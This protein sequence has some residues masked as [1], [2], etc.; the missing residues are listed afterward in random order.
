MASKRNVRDDLNRIA[1]I[2]IE[3]ALDDGTQQ[4]QQKPK[5]RRMGVVKTLVAGAALVGAARI[6]V[7]RAPSLPRVPNLP[8]ISD[9]SDLG[10]RVR[11]RLDEVL[12]QPDVR[13]DDVLDDE[14]AEGSE[15]EE[16]E[17]DDYEDEEPVDQE[18]EDFEDEEPADEEPVDEEDEDFDDEEQADEEP[19]DEE[20]ED[21]EDEPVDAEPEE[22]ADEEPE[23]EEPEDEDLEASDAPGVEVGGNGHAPVDPASLPP[24]P[25]ARRRS[26]K[27][28]KSRS[29]E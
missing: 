2:A 18:D 22:P 25:P 7:K 11:D 8:N 6:A 10:D 24:E 9:L 1:A 23:D 14:E 13:V 12:Q 17:D 5:R 3:S 26:T 4:K 20:D 21:F 19:V 28:R 29:K 16:P 15:D 27:Q